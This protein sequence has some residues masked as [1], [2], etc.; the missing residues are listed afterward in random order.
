MSSLKDKLQTQGSI[1][2]NLNGYLATVPNLAQSSTHYSYSLNGI[3]PKIGFPFPSNLDLNGV[4]PPYN[5]RD[6]TPEN[7]SF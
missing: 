3:P 4:I 1:L 7:K 5:Y 2:S 6:N